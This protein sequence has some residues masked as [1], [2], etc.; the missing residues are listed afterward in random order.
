MCPELRKDFSNSGGM[1]RLIY[2]RRP[3]LNLT[4]YGNL[5]ENLVMA[6]FLQV[7]NHVALSIVNASETIENLKLNSI[8]TIYMT[9]CYRKTIGPTSF[10]QC[11][12]SKFEYK[13]SCVQVDGCVDPSIVASRFSEHFARAY[14]CNNSNQA[15]QLKSVNF[16]LLFSVF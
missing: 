8:L 1:R 7:D 4:N 13:K 15:D 6:Q 3:R 5:W 9:P 2:L 12:R 11:W 14:S 10:W 16:V